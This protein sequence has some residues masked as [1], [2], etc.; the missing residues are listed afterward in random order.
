[1]NINLFPE[2]LYMEIN[3]SS[4]FYLKNNLIE[5]FSNENYTS[6]EEIISEEIISEEDYFKPKVSHFHMKLG[7]KS[8]EHPQNLKIIVGKNEFVNINIKIPGGMKDNSQE[9]NIFKE[10]KTYKYNYKNVKSDEIDLDL[11]KDNLHLRLLKFFTPLHN[12]NEIVGTKISTK[13]KFNIG[14][15]LSVEKLKKLILEPGNQVNFTK[16]L[17]LY[18]NQALF[19]NDDKDKTAFFKKIGIKSEKELAGMKITG[20]D[21][22]DYRI[23]AVW[24][25]DLIKSEEISD[26][27]NC[28][29][30]YSSKRFTKSKEEIT[31]FHK[32]VEKKKAEMKPLG[33][34]EISVVTDNFKLNVLIKPE[35]IIKLFDDNINKNNKYH[36]N[37]RNSIITFKKLEKINPCSI[38]SEGCC[39]DE[40]SFAEYEGDDCKEIDSDNIINKVKLPF[41]FFN[42]LTSRFDLRTIEVDA[43]KSNSEE[44]YY[45]VKVDTSK[46]LETLSVKESDGKIS[47]V[48]P[49]VFTMGS[50]MGL[51]ILITIAI[52]ATL[53]YF[54]VFTVKPKSVKTNIKIPEKK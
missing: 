38:S 48:S 16:A 37:D 50:G 20:P 27:K 46:K 40:E 41:A 43:K 31:F 25:S 15:Y 13:S 1:M 36:I 24:P 42:Y 49:K 5:Q 4:N 3:S 51:S 32:R 2:I 14:K 44:K 39:P 54:F 23:I 12:P 26:S 10:S 30:F 22:M 19:F 52:I 9:K 7:D 11:T 28:I 21:D 17:T 6:E 33:T 8:K 47:L 18:S 45:I 53:L 29:V 35:S 34:F